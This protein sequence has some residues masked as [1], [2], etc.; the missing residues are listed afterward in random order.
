MSECLFLKRQVCCNLALG[1]QSISEGNEIIRKASLYNTLYHCPVKNSFQFN[2]FKVSQEPIFSHSQGAYLQAL[3]PEHH[4][5]PA[6]K[7]QESSKNGWLCG[8]ERRL[9]GIETQEHEGWDLFTP[10]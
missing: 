10:G 8:T 7:Q 2:P 1:T 4:V 9:Y 3:T 6:K 5:R